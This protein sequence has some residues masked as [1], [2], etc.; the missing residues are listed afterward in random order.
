MPSALNTDT[1]PPTPMP[2]TTMF[3]TTW[4]GT[5][6]R[7]ELPGSGEPAGNTV[8]KPPA[9]G[10]TAVTLRA[11]ATAVI[12]MA[13]RPL[14]GTLRISPGAE[15]RE[16]RASGVVEARGHHRVVRVRRGLGRPPPGPARG[17]GTGESTRS[18]APSTCRPRSARCAHGA[19]EQ[20][21]S[22]PEPPLT[23]K[24]GDATAERGMHRNLGALAVRLSAAPCTCTN[25]S[26]IWA[27]ASRRVGVASPSRSPRPST[28]APRASMA[29][30]ASASFGGWL[31]RWMAPS[32]NRPIA[33]LAT[34][35][36]AGA[37]ATRC[38]GLGQLGLQL[39]GGGDQLGVVEVEIVEVVEIVV[40]RRWRGRPSRSRAG[41]G[42]RHA[43][44]TIRCP[45]AAHVR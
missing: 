30:A 17:A 34:I 45:Q 18:A 19:C 5:K 27:R 36:A 15:R 26:R 23:T 3:G 14:I 28:R 35:W 1:C 10:A 11:T 24:S 16:A 37:S 31:L 7:L 40:V 44:L 38:A 32:S 41:P 9:V 25:A 21:S 43:M 22:P 42:R 33:W 12:G 2:T 29:S 4:P 20:T 6:F 13:A 39:L 8:R